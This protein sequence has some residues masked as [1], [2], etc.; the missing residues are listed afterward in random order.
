LAEPI[1]RIRGLGAE[2][3]PVRVYFAKKSQRLVNPV[4]RPRLKR[5]GIGT[6]LLALAARAVLDSSPASGLYL[7]VLEQNAG[8]RAFYSARGGTC[9]ETVAVTP[10]GDDPA[11]LNGRP[12]GL[13]FVWPDPSRLLPTEG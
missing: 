4:G 2:P 13:R 12:M 8:A 9:V 1:L 6:R 7:W 3:A 5:L 10:P 11:R